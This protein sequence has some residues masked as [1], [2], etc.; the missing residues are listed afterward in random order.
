MR[1]DILCICDLLH[2]N[3]WSKHR[4]KQHPIDYPPP[5]LCLTLKD[6]EGAVASLEENLTITSKT[7]NYGFTTVLYEGKTTVIG[8][9]LLIF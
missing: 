3:D 5:G 7:K 4:H 6:R 2:R 8:Y 9:R 1:E